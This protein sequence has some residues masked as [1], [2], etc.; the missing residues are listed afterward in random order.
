MVPKTSSGSVGRVQKPVIAVNNPGKT[1]FSEVGAQSLGIKSPNNSGL[2]TMKG[3]SNETSAFTIRHEK[4]IPDGKIVR[5][6]SRKA[7]RMDSLLRRPRHKSGTMK[8]DGD[9]MQRT[10]APLTYEDTGQFGNL[11]LIST[12]RE[13]NVTSRTKTN[14]ES[15]AQPPAE[16]DEWVAKWHGKFNKAIK[17]REIHKTKFLGS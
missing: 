2:A 16:Y 8:F 4:G 3:I 15:Y 7:E 1:D 14:R 9:N 12:L 13:A 5:S 17:A 10:I 11:P 6:A